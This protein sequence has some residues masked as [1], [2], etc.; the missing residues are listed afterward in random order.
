[1]T[2]DHPVVSALEDPQRKLERAF[3]D[4]FL[5]SHGYEGTKLSE[6]PDPQMELL[7]KQATAYA[8][9]KLSEVQSRARF[10]HEIHGAET[11]HKPQL[12]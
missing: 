5:R 6:L 12:R 8:S 4:E 3:I 10:V 11:V 9:G 1:M 7:M 2:A